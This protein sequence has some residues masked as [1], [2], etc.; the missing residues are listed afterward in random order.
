MQDQVISQIIIR[1]V[2]G[3]KVNKIDQFRLDSTDL[4]SFGRD[5]SSS[6]NYDAPKDDVVSRKHAVLGVKRGDPP[7][8]VLED[9]RSSNG[10]FVNGSR[11][12]GQVELHPEDTV[13]FG[14]GGPKFIFDIQPRPPGLGARTR[15]MSKFETADTHVVRPQVSEAPT[16]QP[17]PAAPVAQPTTPSAK[18][19]VGKDTVQRMLVQERKKTSQTWI[20][21][22]LAILV[23]VVGGGAWLYLSNRG[24][25]QAMNAQS[26]LVSRQ[27][28]ASP[29]DIAGT[30]AN[31][32]VVVEFGWRLFDASS[33]APV[34]HKKYSA[35]N[36]DGVG[37]AYFAFPGEEPHPWLTTDPG[38]GYDMKQAG[39]GTGVIVSSSGFIL[40]NR[41]VAAGWME[42]KPSEY[43]KDKSGTNAATFGYKLSINENYNKKPGTCKFIESKMPLRD[44]VFKPM[45]DTAIVCDQSQCVVAP[46][47]ALFN[48]RNF[49][50][51]NEFLEVRLP[52]N[53]QVISANL[54]RWSTS[55]DVALIKVDTPQPLRAVE[56]SDKSEFTVGERIVV[57][58]YPAIASKS[59]AEFTEEFGRKRLAI[60]PNPMVTNGLVAQTYRD[61]NE[62]GGKKVYSLVG[63]LIELSGVA[64]GLGNSGGPVFDNSGKVIGL[65]S[66]IAVG[67][68]AGERVSYA[69]PIK[70][71][72]DLLGSQSTP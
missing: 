9:L 24:A 27:L 41:H 43:A 67:D 53:D 23:F 55:A 39:F 25:L 29:S 40:T 33:G 61:S 28:G 71:G 31:A 54:V 35:C 46:Q 22:L 50:G 45:E 7:S 64:T 69:V 8:F 63:D 68:D 44:V 36:G 72:R 57:L 26:N 65:F 17:V 60:V 2:S 66:A 5:V 13:E 14:P 16:A 21:G 42:L 49:L 59:A 52:G 51:R 20:G 1:H 37:P 15:V 3:A 6:I 48:K 58:G 38:D 4:I 47:N 56:L 12:T 62:R 19:G 32:V 18:V 11:L 70:A 10:T 34:Y 30:Y